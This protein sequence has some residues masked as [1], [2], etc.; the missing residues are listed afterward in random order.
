MKAL[1]CSTENRDMQEVIIDCSRITGA[2]Q[3]HTAF[4]EALSFPAWYGRNLDGL[5]DCL[6]A[7]CQDTALRL[8]NFEDLGGYGVGV[9]R[10]LEDAC[11]SNSHLH[12]IWE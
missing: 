1:N 12:L 2:E 6:T 11:Q 9:S 7:I 3:L 5:Y 10:V 8:Q 4:A